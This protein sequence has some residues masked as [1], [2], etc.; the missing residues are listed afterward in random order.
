MRRTGAIPSS[1]SRG[2][3]RC[4][5]FRSS[6]IL[7]AFISD[8]WCV[9]S[10]A[11]L[12]EIGE[13]EWLNLVKMQQMLDINVMGSVRTIRTFLP[14]LRKSKGRIILCSSVFGE[15]C[16][17]S[18][19]LDTSY[20]RNVLHVSND[21]AHRKLSESSSKKNFSSRQC[22]LPGFR[23]VFDE[24]GRPLEFGRRAQTRTPAMGR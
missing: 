17:L 7:T 15:I 14:N 4:S 18:D 9:V 6:S 19:D 20:C 8:L 2:H 10:N 16:Y 21:T 23:R 22:C 13:V 24:P 11:G 5:S 12:C 3:W 1:V